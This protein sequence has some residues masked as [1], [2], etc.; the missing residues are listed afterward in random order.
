MQQAQAAFAASSPR[1][2]A[3]YQLLQAAQSLN[4]PFTVPAPQQLQQEQQHFS[5]ASGSDASAATAAA[6]AAAAGLSN[7]GGAA[8]LPQVAAPRAVDSG[9]PPLLLA[10]MGVFAPAREQQQHGGGGSSTL[11]AEAALAGLSQQREWSQE[12]S[13]GLQDQQQPH[14]K[15]ARRGGDEGGSSCGS[16]VRHGCGCGCG[17]GCCLPALPPDTGGWPGCAP[18]LALA[19]HPDMC[20]LCVLPP[21]DLL[22][23]P[24]K[25]HPLLAQGP[26]VGAAAVQCLRVSECVRRS[27]LP[28]L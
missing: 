22:Q 23:L 3:A 1:A 9:V 17:A 5:T 21:A 7:D 25:Q 6:V 2:V 10:A 26:G 8:P 11:D 18:P 27:S 12:G 15:R 13:D 28:L 20:V 24:H 19:C 16:K 4:L 14:R